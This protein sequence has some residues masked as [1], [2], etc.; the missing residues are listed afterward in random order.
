ML[1]EAASVSGSGTAGARNWR[2]ELTSLPNLLT[3]GRVAIIPV[4]LLFI[5]NYSPVRSFVATV[6]YILASLTDLLDGYIARKRGEVS[7]VGKFLDPL[8]DK[9]LVM[10]ALVYL[11]A[12]NRA[13]AWL[14]VSLLA[15]DLAITGL[16]SIASTEG[17][18][19]SASVGGKTKTALQVIGILFLLVHFRYPLLG[20]PG[21]VLDFHRIG[22]L[23][24]VL[25]LGMSVFSALEY[26]K[27]FVQAMSRPRPG[28]SPTA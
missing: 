1:A 27:L 5:D 8:A 13:P 16:R 10:S 4:V 26:I 6:L 28:S 18:V 19:I 11:V 22:F 2:A 9:L 20:L 15:R 3:L 24:L 12:A 25:S 23:T 17:L 14:V 7:V 21:R